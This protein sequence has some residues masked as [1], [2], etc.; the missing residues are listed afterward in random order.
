MKKLTQENFITK[1]KQIHGDKYDYSKCVYNG[2]N[3]KVCIICPEH[4]EFWQ[5]PSNHLKGQGCT[6]CGKIK[7]IASKIKTNK[8]YI[9][10]VKEIYG[11]KYDYK[12]IDYI[13]CKNKICITCREHGDFYVI[14]SKFLRGQECPICTK[15]KINLLLTKTNNEF[16]ETSTKIHDNYYSYEKTKYVNDHTKVCII[17]P[18]H[19]EFWQTPSNHLRGKGCPECGKITQGLKRR[20]KFND[21]LK[22]ANFLHHNKYKYVKNTYT[23]VSDY[24]TIICPIHG[25]FQ[26]KGTMHLIGNGCPYCQQSYPEQIIDSFLKNKNIN[27]I[28]QKRFAW[29]GNKSLDFYLPD[30]NIAIEYQGEQ[31]FKIVDFGGEGFEEALKKYEKGKERDKI[32]EILCKENSVKL[33]YII[34]TE[35]IINKLNDILNNKT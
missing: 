35:D 4:G 8:K 1:A 17:C 32:K 25:E 15:N 16:V 12:K 34:Y 29:L 27:F 22:S 6:E 7:S 18:E 23:K 19:G 28:Y 20:L 11:D 24:L 21:F 33:Y 10:E 9:E 26:Q 14:P 3:A 30:Y 31:H 13:N 2:Y 5:T